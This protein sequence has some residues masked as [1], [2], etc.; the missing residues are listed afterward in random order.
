MEAWNGARWSNGEQL[1][2]SGGK[3]GYVDLD[4][5]ADG[6]LED[7]YRLDIYFTRAPDYGMVEVSLDGKKLGEIFDGFDEEVVP[8]GK[9]EFGEVELTKGHHCLRFTVIDKNPRSTNYFMGIDCL[10]LKP[11]R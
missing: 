2:C 8:S 9:I 3:R 10:D 7:R 1:F 6:A 4:I 11:V 5:L